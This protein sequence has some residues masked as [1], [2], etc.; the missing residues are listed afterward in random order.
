MANSP[1]IAYDK[2]GNAIQGENKKS[3]VTIAVTGNGYIVFPEGSMDRGG[4]MSWESIYS[5]DNIESLVFFLRE[6]LQEPKLNFKQAVFDAI[7]KGEL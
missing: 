3:M 4:T 6:N 2:N 1:I 7:R 5:F